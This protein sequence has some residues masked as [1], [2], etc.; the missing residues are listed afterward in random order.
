MMCPHME[1]TLNEYVD[2]MLA[3]RARATVEAHLAGCAGCRTAVAELRALV[4]GAAALPKT[5]EPSRDLWATIEPRIVQR[6]TWNVQRVWWRGALAAAAVLVIALGLYRL[7]PPSTAPYRPA[8]QGWAA[9]QADFDRATNELSL[10]LAAQRGRLRPETVALV[11]RNLGIIDA[12]IAES[13]AALARDTA[14]AEL[15]HLWAAAARQ[16]VELLRW[17]TRVAAS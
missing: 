4:A 6:A 14:N 9:V 7:L 8:G 15:Q 13:R 10:I 17:A 16:K 3:A 5:V 1:T 2:G 11:E 12:A